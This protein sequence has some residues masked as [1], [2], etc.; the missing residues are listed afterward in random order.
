MLG[1]GS[2]SPS[3]LPPRV[4]ALPRRGASSARVATGPPR[5]GALLSAADAGDSPA[6]PAFAR[7]LEDMM[8]S[9]RPPDAFDVFE[10]LEGLTYP[11]CSW[12]SEATRRARSRNN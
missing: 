2:A 10:D 5:A 12:R 7:S 8:G 3:H 11:R 9:P 1:R 6:S 4:P